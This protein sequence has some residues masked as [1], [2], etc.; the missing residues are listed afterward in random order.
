MPKPNEKEKKP[1]RRPKYGMLSCVAYMYRMLWKYERT[2]AFVGFFTVPVSLG[3]SALALY[4]PSITLRYLE[5]SERFSTV[6]LIILGLSLADILLSLAEKRISIETV[7]SKNY[8]LGRMQYRLNSRMRDRDFFLEYDPEIKKL[9]QRAGRSIGSNRAKG[10]NFPLNFADMAAAVCKFFLF[11]SIISLLS[12]WIILLLAAGC[13]VDYF[14]GA[15]ERRRNYETQ[16][17]INIIGKKINYISFDITRDLKYGK[18]IRLYHFRDYLSLLA[19]KLLGQYKKEQEKIELRHLM[20]EIVRLL[21]IVL[22]DGTAY[23]FLIFKA[24]AGEV[25]A[26]QFVLYFSAITKMA[27]FM[28]NLLSKW[29]NICEGALQISDYREDLEVEDRLNR[30]EG[31]PLPKGAFSIEFKNVSFQYPQGEKKILDHVSFKIEAG[32]KIALVGLNGA[33]KTTM[34]KLMCGLLLPTEGEILLDGHTLYEYNRDELYTLFGLVPQNYNLLPVSIAANI[35]C[36]DED[37]LIDRDRLDTCISY[38]GL[39]EKISSLPLG[40]DTPLNRQIHFN[41]IEFSG[42]EAQKLLLARLLYRNPKCIILDEPTAALDPIAEDRMYHK[43]NEMTKISFAGP[44]DGSEKGSKESSVNCSAEGSANHS[45]EGATSIFISHRLASTRFCDRVFL[46]DGAVI[47]ETGTHEEL[48]A[49]GG[50]YRQ[51]FDLQSRY[52]KE[53]PEGMSELAEA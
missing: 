45:K 53:N 15:L 3:M 28:S 8:I 41:G 51:L 47:A 32:E 52:Y 43:Y 44:S 20:A 4:I 49:A 31:I 37:E 10:V 36:T 30:G 50:K 18:D 24:A 1:K 14:L 5:R 27:G 21:V 17:R 12:P 2:L 6:A 46:L 25:D 34:T 11:G 13:A 38:A 22:R 35:A 23:A 9:D 7:L 39:S 48:M 42:G 19:K 40:A 26:A 16:D 29:S 33:G